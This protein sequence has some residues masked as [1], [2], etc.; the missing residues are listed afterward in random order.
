[1]DQPRIPVSLDPDAGGD[2]VL[3]EQFRSNL[4]M[5]RRLSPDLAAQF[6]A[7]KQTHS[8]LVKVGDDDWDIEFRGIPLYGTGAKAYAAA[9]MSDSRNTMHRVVMSSMGDSDYDSFA[10]KFH[11]AIDERIAAEGVSVSD[12][13]QSPEAFHVICLGVGLGFQLPKILDLTGCKHLILVEVNAEF[14][15]H[16]L[17]VFD[18]SQILDPEQRSGLTVNILRE[19][20]QL[21]TPIAIRE[22]IRSFNPALFEGT[23]TFFHYEN[24]DYVALFRTI[25]KDISLALSGLGFMSDEFRMVRNTYLNLK[26]D[27]TLLF[28]TLPHGSDWPVIVVGS[29]PSLDDTIETLRANAPRAVVICCGTAL[30]AL[31]RYGIRPDIFAV[32][33]NGPEIYDYVKVAAD[34][35]G[36][37]G[38]TL[39]G[40]TTIDPRMSTL[41]ERTVQYMRGG[42]SSYQ[43]FCQDP[44]NGLIGGHPTVTNTGF[45][46][47]IGLGFKTIYLFGV[48]LGSREPAR[49]H[50]AHSPYLADDMD[51]DGVMNKP[52]PGNLGGMVYA[53]YVLNWS[54]DSFEQTI[55]SQ[56]RR[57][58]V[59]NCS[60]GAFI[61]GTTPKLASTLTLPEPTTSKSEMLA[62]LWAHYAP[63]GPERFA[64][65][66]QVDRLITQVEALRDSLLS[67]LGDETTGLR[68]TIATMVRSL[69]DPRPGPEQNFLR[70]TVFQEMIIAIFKFNRV[71]EEARAPLERLIR[72][73]LAQA[74]TEHTTMVSDFLRDIDSGLERGPW[75]MTPKGAP[76]EW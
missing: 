57:L 68:A 50:S 37:E 59:F 70:G 45:G 33:E 71:K 44:A 14:L 24:N 76:S 40:P 28:S 16:S 23:T 5:F 47:A 39:F 12:D 63:Y 17:Y 36:M 10:G 25:M 38:I 19:I 56:I 61:R 69:L 3:L 11:K 51:Y 9:Q 41:F 65:S 35:W 54:R 32:L 48:D 4:E 29:G 64:K 75:L 21:A 43:I 2:P 22:K 15:Y 42:L 49:H 27:Q 6:E 8:V 52:V 30:P 34:T 60:D 18:W 67:A 20:D 13:L 72:E 26:P 55:Y 53:D 66:W 58:R 46:A 74:I 73:L 62:A 1:M 31:L 7:V